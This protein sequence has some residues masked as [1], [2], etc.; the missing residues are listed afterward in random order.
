MAIEQEQEDLTSVWIVEDH[1]G[2]RDAVRD[3]V[4]AAPGLRC[5]LAARTGEEAVAALSGSHPP[6]VVLMDLEL[7]GM[8]GTQTTA[9]ILGDRPDT[10]VIALTVHRDDARILDAIRV[11]AVGYLLKGA[12]EEEIVEAVSTALAGGSPIDA[13]IARRVLELFS[14]RMPDEVDA[15][16]PT[17]REIQILQ[18]FASGQTQS[19]VAASLFLSPHTID[20]HVRNIYRKLGVRTQAAAVAR[21]IK[22]G[23]I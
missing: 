6:D 12:S 4:D 8:D 10:C 9:A 18:R 21:A 22:R 1:A 20:S 19:E 2:F 13:R 16:A 11:G 15:P 17:P 23:L 3:T 14:A 5:T 7:P